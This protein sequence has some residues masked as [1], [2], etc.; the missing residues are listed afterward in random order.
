MRYLQNLF[1][2]QYNNLL[3]LLFYCDSPIVT[4]DRKIVTI[5]ETQYSLQVHT[6]RYYGDA[7]D[8]TMRRI[9]FT[10]TN[11]MLYV[12]DLTNKQTLKDMEESFEWF[13][14]IKDDERNDLPIVIVGNK[15]DLIE[16]DEK[17]REI[18][19]EMISEII[20]KVSKNSILKPIYI[21]T[22][23]KTGENI[24]EAFCEAIR[25]TLCSY[26]NWNDI[27]E[28]ILLNGDCETVFKELEIKSNKC[29]LM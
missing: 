20:E 27:V 4:E 22:S 5:D 19:K 7:N 16:Q 9:F 11:G 2:E 12:C 18:T 24:E 23:A 21:E 13:K 15:L 14:R 6:S 25:L 29:I 1:E 8:A 28:K 10:W 17:K 26:F 3:N